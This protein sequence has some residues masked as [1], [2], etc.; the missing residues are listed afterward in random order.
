MDIPEIT[1]CIQRSLEEEVDDDDDFLLFNG[2]ERNDWY[3]SSP[4]ILAS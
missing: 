4:M 1:V 2:L 3:G